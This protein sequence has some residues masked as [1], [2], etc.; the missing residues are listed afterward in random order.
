MNRF[1]ILL[2]ALAMF[3]THAAA[4]PISS[5]KHEWQDP[6]VFEVNKLPP[7]NSAWPCPDSESAWKSTYDHSPWVRSLN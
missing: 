1:P 4:A 2:A 5:S 7:R 3:A 6:Q